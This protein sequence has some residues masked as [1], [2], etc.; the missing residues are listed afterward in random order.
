MA[1]TQHTDLGDC[2][3]ADGCRPAMVALNGPLVCGPYLGETDEVT[4][5]QADWTGV[6]LTEW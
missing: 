4:S 5:W 3:G 2:L 1:C 6:C